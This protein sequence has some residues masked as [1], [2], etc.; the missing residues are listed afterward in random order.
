MTLISASVFEPPMSMHGGLILYN[1][2]FWWALYFRTNWWI[3]QIHKVLMKIKDLYH[4]TSAFLESKR[5]WKLS[6]L[7]LSRVLT[8]QKFSHAK[9]KCCTVLV[10]WEAVHNEF[11]ESHWMGSLSLSTAKRGDNAL[12]SVRPS[13]RPSVCV[14]VCPS[15]DTHTNGRTDATNYII[16]LASPSINITS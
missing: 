12:G 5:S 8:M 1:T 10:F 13:V 4:S 14:C 6:A 3:T 16:S 11:I 9:I 15:S 7:E 2:L